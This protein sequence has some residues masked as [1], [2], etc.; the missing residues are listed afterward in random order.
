[1]CPIRR[2]MKKRNPSSGQ[3]GQLVHWWLLIHS[4]PRVPVLGKWNRRF[5]NWTCRYQNHHPG[6]RKQN[7]KPPSSLLVR[8]GFVVSP[9]AERRRATTPRSCLF[10]FISSGTNFDRVPSRLE[11]FNRVAECCSSWIVLLR[12][13]SKQIGYFPRI[14]AR[15]FFLGSSRLCSLL[16]L[17]LLLLRLSLSF[18]LRVF[19]FFGSSSSSSSSSSLYPFFVGL[20]SLY[21]CFS[22]ARFF[23]NEDPDPG[24]VFFSSSG[25]KYPAVKRIS[26]LAKQSFRSLMGDCFSYPCVS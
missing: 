26:D 20:L 7:P 15:L 2:R 19:F 18:S 14:C 6:T 8:F 16:L 9:C 21:S 5:S 22:F 11:I 10:P 4:G 13:D 3:N 25:I 12:L 23:L 1:M 17:L 24:W